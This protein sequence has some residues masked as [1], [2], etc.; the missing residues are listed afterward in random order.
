MRNLQLSKKLSPELILKALIEKADI[1]IITKEIV[2]PG[3]SS[4]VGFSKLEETKINVQYAYECPINLLQEDLKEIVLVFEES[5]DFYFEKSSGFGDD[6]LYE[7]YLTLEEAYDEFECQY[8]DL[9]ED[10]CEIL[11]PRKIYEPPDIDPEDRPN[12]LVSRGTDY[13][14]SYWQVGNRVGFVSLSHE[15]REL[16]IQLEIGAFD[17]S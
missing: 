5:N 16:P 11:G 17:L 1:E 9:V 12:F 7:D 15:D 14:Q 8:E 3:K 2:I 13:M 6:H 4:I 10:C